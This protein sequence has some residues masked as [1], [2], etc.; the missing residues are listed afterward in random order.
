MKTIKIQ[1]K[2]V[3][4]HGV[5]ISLTQER[6]ATIGGFL[7]KSGAVGTGITFEEMKKWMPGILGVE[8]SDPKFRQEVNKYFNNIMITVPYEGKELN[9]TVDESGE[10]EVLE[11]YLRYKFCLQHPKVADSK[12]SADVDQYK[13]YYIEDQALEL[14][15][16]TTKLKSKTNATIKFAELIN[17]EVKLDWVLRELTTKYPKELGSITRLTS[18]GKDEKELKVAEIFEKDPEYF[19]SV[20][21]DQDLLFKAQIASM[22]ESQVIQKVGNEYVYGSEPLGDLNASI[23][24]LK[25]PNN[26]EAYVIMLAKLNNMGIGFKQKETKKVEKSK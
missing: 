21:S 11:D 14:T 8:S 25:N 2:E 9:I 13:E 4:R 22:V 12:V 24:Y 16:R 23:A 10:P 15:K 26:S 18:L 1:R 20:V 5:H 6:S 3:R 17:D 19:M 7:L